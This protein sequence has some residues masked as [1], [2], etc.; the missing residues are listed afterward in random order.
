MYLIWHDTQ[1]AETT[2]CTCITQ[3][4]GRTP[5]WKCRR[6]V[7]NSERDFLIMIIFTCKS[8]I[9]FI[10]IKNFEPLSLPWFELT[11]P[12]QFK[13]F[14]SFRSGRTLSSFSW[15]GYHAIQNSFSPSMDFC[16]FTVSSNSEAPDLPGTAVQ[17]QASWSGSAP[18]V[19][20]KCC[21]S[22]QS[23]LN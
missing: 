22:L 23:S 3:H 17:I 2:A 12:F 16:H 8:L 19:L 6:K 14:H 1:C 18:G 4:F 11:F 7:R 13:V 5:L 15:Q 21:P 9:I 20:P 10:I